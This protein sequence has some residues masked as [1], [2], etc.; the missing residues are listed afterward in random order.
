MIDTSRE[1]NCLTNLDLMPQSDSK[2]SY[3]EFYQ[4][5]KPAYTPHQRAH[6]KVNS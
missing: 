3:L 4:Q 1:A 6:T 2:Y 5:Y